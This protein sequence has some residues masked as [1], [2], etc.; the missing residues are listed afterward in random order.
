MLLKHLHSPKCSTWNIVK[1]RLGTCQ[2][3]FYTQKFK[4][5]IWSDYYFLCPQC[6]K[7]RIEAW[8]VFDFDEITKRDGGFPN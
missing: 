5:W 6:C 8:G 4:Y 2:T 3:C 7:N 1:E